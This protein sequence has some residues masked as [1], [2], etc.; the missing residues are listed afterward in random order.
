VA[1]VSTLVCFHAHP[2]DE[3]IATGGVMAKSAA[4]GHRVVLVTATKG[5]EGEPVPGV[6]GD[7]EALWERREVETHRSAEVLGVE[8]VEFLGYEDSG[9]MGEPTNE[10]PACFWQADVEVAA[11]R[12]ATILREVDA[13]VVTI[14]DD[15]GGYGHPDHIQV[16]RVGRRAA[17]MAGVDSVFEATMNRTRIAQLLSER[18]AELEAVLEENPDMESPGADFGTPEEFITHAVDVSAFIHVKRQSMMCHESQ[19]SDE[20]FFMKMPLDAFAAAFGTEWF[21]RSGASRATDEPFGD[22]LFA[23]VVAD[24]DA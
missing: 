21:M 1:G 14:Y 10:N 4:A 3:S 7:G 20:S 15:H 6:L 23:A 8:R 24:A 13:D 2:D 16:H 11:A 5:E 19:I 22:T 12:L 18:T 9:M 17:E